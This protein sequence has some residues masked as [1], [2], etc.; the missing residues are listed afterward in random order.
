MQEQNKEFPRDKDGSGSVASKHHELG[1]PLKSGKDAA[2]NF[3]NG[4][5][6]KSLKA[7]ELYTLAIGKIIAK[8]HIVISTNTL[9]DYLN[10]NKYRLIETYMN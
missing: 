5:K 8:F 7:T 6:M 3:D 4:S 9:Q 2:G 10:I 1:S